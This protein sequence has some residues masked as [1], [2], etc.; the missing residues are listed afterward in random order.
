MKIAQ[1]REPYGTSILQEFE[2]RITPLQPTSAS[3]NSDVTLAS[4]SWKFILF[5][6]G[7]LVYGWNDLDL[8]QWQY[9]NM[10]GS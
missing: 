10:L 4:A 2:M 8:W 1:N 6:V 3:R 5:V 9:E 7:T